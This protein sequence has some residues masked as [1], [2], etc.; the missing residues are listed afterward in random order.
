M[1]PAL[2]SALEAALGGCLPSPLTLWLPGGVWDCR[3]KPGSAVALVLSL[4]CC[5]PGHLLPLLVPVS[6]V[7]GRE[8]Q[9]TRRSFR[10]EACCRCG[11]VPGVPHV[12]CVLGAQTAVVIA[13]GPF[14]RNYQLVHSRLQVSGS[15]GHRP[16]SNPNRV[17][18]LLSWGS[19]SQAEPRL[20]SI[21]ALPL[22][23]TVPALSL[24]L[25]GGGG[26]GHG[27]PCALP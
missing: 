26:P 4:H 21:L 15:Q 16:C 23:L 12:A 20:W 14:G 13:C 11:A 7:S 10:R 19:T 8:G 6:T 22:G 5:S 27:D 24:L 17:T 18:V 9:A 2:C 3:R 25:W 1:C